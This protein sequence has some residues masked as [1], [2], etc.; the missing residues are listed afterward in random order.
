[1]VG[2]E[3]RVNGEGRGDRMR[4]VTWEVCGW[5]MVDLEGRGVRED[6]AKW[7]GVNTNG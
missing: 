4:G 7:R 1:V 3:G 5:L 6:G 2:G